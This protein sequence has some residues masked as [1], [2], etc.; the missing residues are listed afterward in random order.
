MDFTQARSIHLLH[1]FATPK[2][3]RWTTALMVAVLSILN[4]LTVLFPIQQERLESLFAL[5]NAFEP[6]VP[7]DWIF[8]IPVVLW[9]SS[10]AFSFS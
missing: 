5:L 1:S 4:S 7:S 6:F 10:S 8:S 3:I 9:L 2:K